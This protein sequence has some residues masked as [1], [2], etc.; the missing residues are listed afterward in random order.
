MNDS[1]HK[2]PERRV[3]YICLRCKYQALTRTKSL[4]DILHLIA[5]SLMQGC[6]ECGDSGNSHVTLLTI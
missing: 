2:W 1:I 4:T 6:T 3:E 5:V